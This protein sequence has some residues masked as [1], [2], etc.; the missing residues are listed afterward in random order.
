MG[1][2]RQSFANFWQKHDKPVYDTAE[3]QTIMNTELE[4]TL[5]TTTELSTSS[6]SQ[7]QSAQKDYTKIFELTSKTSDED[8]IEIITNVDL[9]RSTFWK[10]QSDFE[11][12]AD[13]LDESEEPMLEPVVPCLGSDLPSKKT[14]TYF[15]KKIFDL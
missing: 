12:L 9:T 3:T 11:R 14:P 1:W 10:D 5:F 2:R 6:V 15:G 8:Y 4:T 7:T 13:L